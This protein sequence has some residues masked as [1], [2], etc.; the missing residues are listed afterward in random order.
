LQHFCERHPRWA[1]FLHLRRDTA[2]EIMRG[3]VSALM[4]P[5]SIGMFGVALCGLL[6]AFTI[7]TSDCA[8]GET[9]L[10]LPGIDAT[11][12]AHVTPATAATN[13]LLLAASAFAC[14]VLV[15]ILGKALAA[16]ATPSTR[17]VVRLRW[18]GHLLTLNL[19]TSLFLPAW[20]DLQAGRPG[21]G[22]NAGLFPA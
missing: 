20:L 1:R 18:L 14:C 8:N 15:R 2:P 16:G 13:V 11:A 12:M 7:S 4:S 19:F 17:I 10:L 5:G 9:L 22:F 3:Y 6:L 21:F